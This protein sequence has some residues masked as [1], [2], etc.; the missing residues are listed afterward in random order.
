MIKRE[1][2]CDLCG[3]EMTKNEIKKRHIETLKLQLPGKNNKRTINFSINFTACDS[4]LQNYIDLLLTYQRESR[5]S[6]QE[7][8]LEQIRAELDYIE[9]THNLTSDDILIDDSIVNICRNCKKEV[10]KLALGYGS[11]DKFVNIVTD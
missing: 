9:T 4:F 1:Y 3:S 6:K 7:E 11:F 8:I 5:E 10:F 2:Y